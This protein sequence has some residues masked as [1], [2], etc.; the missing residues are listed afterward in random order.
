MNQTPVRCLHRFA[1]FIVLVSACSF[2]SLGLIWAEDTPISTK[3]SERPFH[4]LVQAG[5]YLALGGPAGYGPT[6]I[7][8]TLPGHFSGRYGL[9]AEWRR[10]GTSSRGSVLGALLFE[11]GASRP[12]L[13]LKL[14]V[15]AGLTDNQKPIAGA[16][17]EWSL[18][19]VGPL[20]VSTTT[21]LDLIF[22]GADSRPAL[23]TSLTIHLGQ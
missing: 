6:L 21:T 19:A 22:D 7:I 13:A 10:E 3:E 2:A 8:E 4:F 5:G 17:I 14:L 9:R 20:G 18:W 1:L 15:E 16:G 11:A 23:S 12:K